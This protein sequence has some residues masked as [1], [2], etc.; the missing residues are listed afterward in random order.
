MAGL[1]MRTG[2]SRQGIRRGWEHKKGKFRV[3]K[4]EI[5]GQENHSR[6]T[7]KGGDSELDNR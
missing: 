3:E 6:K 7:G 2:T 4:I 1:D 5:V